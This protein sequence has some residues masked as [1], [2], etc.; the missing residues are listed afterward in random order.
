M[1]V[2]GLRPVGFISSTFL[3]RL[4]LGSGR[5][6]CEKLAWEAVKMQD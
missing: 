1:F 6:E 3:L 4:L 5:M 2:D